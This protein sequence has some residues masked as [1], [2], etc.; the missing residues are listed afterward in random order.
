MIKLYTLNSGIFLHLGNDMKIISNS[1]REYLSLVH[2]R[3][4]LVHYFL[5]SFIILFKDWLPPSSTQEVM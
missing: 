4:S 5:T 3:S 2:Q 1:E